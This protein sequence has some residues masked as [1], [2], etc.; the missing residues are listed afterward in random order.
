MGRPRIYD[1]PEEFDAVVD[2]YVEGKVAAG[3]PVTLTGLC[4]ALGFGDKSTLYDYQKREGFSHSVS[5]ARMWVEHEY[6]T[7]MIQGQ[8]PPGSATFVLKNFG[9]RDKQ[10]VEMAGPGGG[11][12]VQE[13]VRR[14]VDPADADGD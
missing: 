12:M 3:E 8:I 10:E 4:I 1:S 2:A 14:I 9:W 6:E 11:P 5:R 7:R 13:I